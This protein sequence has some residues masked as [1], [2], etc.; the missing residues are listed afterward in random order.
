MDCSRRTETLSAREMAKSDGTQLTVPAK[1]SYRVDGVGSNRHGP[2]T[3]NI[4]TR[5]RMAGAMLVIFPVLRSLEVQSKDC[6]T[7]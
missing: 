5:I 7:L 2:L 3:T 1:P 4:P 6:L